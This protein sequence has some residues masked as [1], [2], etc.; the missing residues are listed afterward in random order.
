[1]LPV[2]GRL[3]PRPGCQ[4][5]PGAGGKVCA[6]ALYWQDYRKY[7]Q[8]KES[9]KEA[10]VEKVTDMKEILKFGVMKTPA[11]VIDEKVVISGRVAT[12]KELKEI[13]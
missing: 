6:E 13:I 3:F 9:G 5:G 12:I 1:M 7:R 4:G 11:L 2:G 10:E 8:E